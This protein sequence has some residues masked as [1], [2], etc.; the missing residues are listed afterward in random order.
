MIFQAKPPG[1]DFPTDFPPIQQE[2]FPDFP[3]SWRIM[4]LENWYGPVWR[5]KTRIGDESD[6]QGENHLQYLG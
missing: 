6:H 4:P 5:K 1:D 2:M 3:M